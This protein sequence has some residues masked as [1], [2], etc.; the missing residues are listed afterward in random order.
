MKSYRQILTYD[1]NIGY[2]FV[3]NINFTVV[4]DP[5]DNMTDYVIKTDSLGYRNERDIIEIGNYEKKIDIDVLYL[6][7]S[8]TAGDGVDNSSNSS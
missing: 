5:D 1:S 6:S 8:F 2:K 4:G 3:P 7:C